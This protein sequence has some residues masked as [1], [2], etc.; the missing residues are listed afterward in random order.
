M[1]AK[2]IGAFFQSWNEFKNFV[3]AEIRLL[4]LWPFRVDHFLLPE[5]CGI[6]HS[7]LLLHWLKVHL[8]VF[9]SKSEMMGP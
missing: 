2:H 9:C 7:L 1:I 4:F 3:A 5:Y 8:I 6:D